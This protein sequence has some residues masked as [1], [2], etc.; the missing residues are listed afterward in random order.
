M[1]LAI[2]TLLIIVL[3]TQLVKAADEAAEREPRKFHEDRWPTLRRYRP[4][5]MPPDLANFG[6]ESSR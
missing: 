5:T 4:I 6:S 1:K 3:G 2:T